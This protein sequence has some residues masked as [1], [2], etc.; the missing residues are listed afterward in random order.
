MVNRPESRS[1]SSTATSRRERH[2]RGSPSSTGSPTTATYD[3]PSSS[4][5]RNRPSALR[6]PRCGGRRCSATSPRASTTS[7]LPPTSSRTRVA[8]SPSS[9]GSRS[10]SLRSSAARS[11]AP[12]E[13]DR[14]SRVSLERLTPSTLGAGFDIR[15]PGDPQCSCPRR[16]GQRGRS[17]TG[18]GHR[19]GRRHAPRAGVR[20]GLRPGHPA[21]PVGGARAADPR[22][23]GPDGR[24]G[25]PARAPGPAAALLR[26]GAQGVRRRSR[27]VAGRRSTRYLP[28]ARWS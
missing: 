7:A 11:R 1:P 9:R 5:P 18:P 27:R 20:A 22:G 2:S 13:R 8:G 23:R 12:R 3:V 4:R 19:R 14:S 24:H 25:G 16:P 17:R 28:G 10:G 21:P 6:S 26:A 15:C